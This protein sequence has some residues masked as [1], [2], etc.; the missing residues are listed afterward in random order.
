MSNALKAINKRVKA[1][2]KKHPKSKRSTLQ[3]QAG[4]EW[5][6]GKLKARRKK[7]AVKK[8]VRKKRATAKRT[9]RKVGKPTTV[10]YSLGKLIKRKRRKAAP[11]KRSHT[12]R[13]VSGSGKSSLTPLLLVG[14]LGLAAYMLFKSNAAPQQ[15]LYTTN[16]PQRDASANNILLYAT[17][18]GMTAKA[19]ADL[20][21]AINKS[22][23]AAVINA[24]QNP[25]TAIDQLLSG[26]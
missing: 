25:Q 2:A 13:K 23:D 5:K 26:D 8:V 15:Q 20:I 19:I 14:G 22:S 3:K 7:V 9:P 10:V 6:A 12:R 24:A 21:N 18:A 1:L 17:A 4:R 16:N 11:K